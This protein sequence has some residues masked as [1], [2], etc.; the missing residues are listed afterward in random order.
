MM[1]NPVLTAALMAALL[2]G[3]ATAEGASEWYLPIA[4]E[5]RQ[6]LKEVR[7]T[8]IGDFGRPRKARPEARAHLH[9]GLDFMRPGGYD[10]EA[11]IF[12]IGPGT[13]ISMRDDGPFA[14]IIVAHGGKEKDGPWSV[15]EHVAGITVR[16]GDIVTPR[17]PMA[18]FMTGAELDRYGWQFDHLH[19]EV[20]RRAPKPVR[21]TERNPHR[22]FLSPNLDC[23]DKAELA[24]GYFDPGRFLDSAWV[25]AAGKKDP[26]AGAAATTNP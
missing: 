1:F 9:A 21:P 19:L 23:L 2:M 18:R 16:P 6:S 5:D 10:R 7:I 4:V 15:Y 26:K 14:Q 13:V 24:R 12:P 3:E 8:R 11:G 25:D 20:L 17:L 22:R